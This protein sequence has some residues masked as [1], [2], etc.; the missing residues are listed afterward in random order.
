MVTKAYLCEVKDLLDHEKVNELKNYTQHGGTTCFEHSV[1]VS[2]YSYK[3]CKLLKWDYKSA[4]RGGLLHDFFL[5]DWHTTSLDGKLHGFEHPKIALNN[6]EKEFEVNNIEKDIILKH[7]W[8]LTISKVPKY[9]ESVVV[10]LMDKYSAIGEM[11]QR[12]ISN[13]AKVK[14]NH[15]GAV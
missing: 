3:I 15:R 14:K 2:L 6:A 1:R 11:T 13:K 8:P 4:A 12:F 7:M 9:K 5:Y 10:S